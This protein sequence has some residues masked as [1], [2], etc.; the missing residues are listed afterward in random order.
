MTAASSSWHQVTPTY[1]W[2][3]DS[4]QQQLGK[5]KHSPHKVLHVNKYQVTFKTYN[6]YSFNYTDGKAQY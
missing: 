3:I 6:F 1:G 5:A 2:T 4:S